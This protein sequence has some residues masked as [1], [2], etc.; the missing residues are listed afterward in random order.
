MTVSKLKRE[1][2]IGSNKHWAQTRIKTT[3]AG[4]FDHFVGAQLT[5]P[6]QLWLGGI[7]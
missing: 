5:I 3:A 2:Y 7:V 6:A 1:H 4:L